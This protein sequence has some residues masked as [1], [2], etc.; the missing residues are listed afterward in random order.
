VKSTLIGVNRY[1]NPVFIN[2]YPW[3]SNDFEC[4]EFINFTEWKTVF[5]SFMTRLFSVRIR[6]SLL[7]CINALQN[8]YISWKIKINSAKSQC[9]FFTK[10]RSPRYLTQTDLSV[11]GSDVPWSADGENFF[12]SS[13]KNWKCHPCFPNVMKLFVV[14][15]ADAKSLF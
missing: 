13:K 6:V 11:C 14:T 4:S 3:K 5:Q 15:F 12:N 8:Y 9:I 7:L 2:D 10:C 1:F